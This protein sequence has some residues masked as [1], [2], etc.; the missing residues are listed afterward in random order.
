MDLDVIIQELAKDLTVVAKKMSW[1][2]GKFQEDGLFR[3]IERC[4]PSK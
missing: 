4:S 3:I 1:W 2:N